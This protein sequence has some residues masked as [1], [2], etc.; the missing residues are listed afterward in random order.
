MF[1]LN[2]DIDD[3]KIFL[4]NFSELDNRLDPVFYSKNLNLNNFIKL[5]K[6]AFVKGG[7][8]IPKGF[9]YSSEET[10]YLYLRVSDFTTD[11]GINWDNVKYIS[12]DV[13]D[14]L[15]RYQVFNGDIIFSIAGTVGKTKLIKNI[16]KNKK[17]ILTE[18]AAVI[19]IKNKKVLPE[20]LFVILGSKILQKQIDLSY[21]QTTIP[22]IGLDRIE[23]LLIPNLNINIQQQIIDIYET[24]YQTK[25][26]KEA[27][28]ERLLESIDDYLLGE[29]GITLPDRDNSL[30]KRMFTVSFCELSGKRFDC[31]YYQSYY[32]ELEKSIKK[33]KYEKFQIKTIVSFIGNGKTPA[34]KDYSEIPTDFPIIK[35]GSYTDAYIDMSKVGYIKDTPSLFAEKGDIYILSAAH[36]ASYVGKQIKY[37]NQN[38]KKKTGF[39]GELICIRVNDT[40]VNSFYLFS[41][42]NLDIYKT[43]LNRE[44]TGQTSHIYAKDIKNI[45][46][47]LPSI[48]K[49]NEI[50]SHIE[51]IHQKA[52][53][54]RAEA[55]EVLEQAKEI[56]EKMIQ[57]E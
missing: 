37:L 40:I 13:F 27:E 29:L 18:N 30:K 17:V 3:N 35:A 50:A 16:P 33:S 57:G 47:S 31:D 54:L 20:S 52:K 44:K 46:I 1:E 26:K 11:N 49:Q 5:K 6:I 25:Q 41:L 21:V 45:Y 39:V 34:A 2:S 23:N 10:D 14:L 32:I 56:V 51:N 28:A 42:L 24:A 55:K 7:K 8:R 15:K 12:K 4:V 38:P 48:E 36:Q 9:S 19:H 53:Q 43:L 22:K